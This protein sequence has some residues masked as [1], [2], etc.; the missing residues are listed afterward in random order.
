MLKVTYLSSG[1][2]DSLNDEMSDKA[3]TCRSCREN[4]YVKAVGQCASCGYRHSIG[5]TT[6]T[7]CNGNTHFI[8]IPNYRPGTA[9]QLIPN[10]CNVCFNKGRVLAYAAGFGTVSNQNDWKQAID[11]KR[12]LVAEEQEVAKVRPLGTFRYE[13][14]TAELERVALREENDKL[15]ANISVKS[16]GIS[17]LKE[18]DELADIR[19]GNRAYRYNKLASSDPRKLISSAKFAEELKARSFFSANID[20]I[21]PRL[22]NEP[23]SIISKTKA[24]YTIN[25]CLYIN[26]RYSSYIMLEYL[27]FREVITIRNEIWNNRSCFNFIFKR[28]KLKLSNEI[29]TKDVERM[30]NV[31]NKLRRLK[32]TVADLNYIRSYAN[33]DREKNRNMYYATVKRLGVVG[34]NGC[35]MSETFTDTEIRTILG[36]F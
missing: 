27:T 17:G 23:G 2:N 5:T 14:S 10:N 29:K 13:Q 15:A 19:Y 34:F 3:T 26:V 21:D 25:G 35:D 16:N 11:L 1:E 33:R 36:I 24:Q 9:P 18:L 12:Q 8:G 28:A 20:Y 7:K 30:A 22:D 31:E 32:K 4:Y 6:C